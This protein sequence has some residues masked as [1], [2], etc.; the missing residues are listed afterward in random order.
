MPENNL[1]VEVSRELPAGVDK[2]YAAWTNPEQL[3]Q[4][5]R[6]MSN[7]LQEVTN[8][9]KQG[10]T[11]RYVFK[12]EGLVISGEYLEVK[13]KEKLV[14]T[15]NWQL[16]KDEVKNTSYQ[17][18]IEFAAQGDKTTIHVT[19]EHFDSEEGIQTHREGW[20]KGLDDLENFLS[21]NN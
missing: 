12:D 18:N 13:E 7:E 6:P 3:K 19:Q 20:E 15:W 1:K 9:L 2:V 17:L 4:W 10:G 8:D 21:A 5:W 16:P 14:Y 11:V